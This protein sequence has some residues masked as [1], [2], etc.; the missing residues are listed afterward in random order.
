MAYLQ[1]PL[2]DE[3]QQQLQNG[4]QT[5]TQSGVLA[6]NS[7]SQQF[8]GTPTS[9]GYVNLDKYV[10]SNDQQGAGLANVVTSGANSA[11]EGAKTNAVTWGDAAKSRVDAGTV[12]DSSNIAGRVKANPTSVNSNEYTALQSASYGGP[13]S[14]QADT[15]YGDVLNTFKNTRQK[16]DSLSDRSTQKSILDDT[17]RQN[18]NQL[19]L[20][21]GQRYTNGFSNLD[22]FILNGDKAGQDSLKGFQDKAKGF[23]SALSDQEGNVGGYINQARSASDAAKA[24]AKAAVLDTRNQIYSGV[25][26]RIGE[27]DKRLRAEASA[28]AQDRVAQLLNNYGSDK[29]AVRNALN[30]NGAIDSANDYISVNGKVG[31]AQAMSADERARLQALASLESAQV[32]A[33]SSNPYAFNEGWFTGELNKA[34]ATVSAAKAVARAK[35]EAEA[36]AKAEADA[37]AAAEA[38]AREEERK[39]QRPENIAV[40]GVGQ[41][42]NYKV[43]NPTPKG[44]W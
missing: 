11:V 8:G 3:E 33:P 1:N 18:P 5:S 4:Q 38:A 10:T 20:Q 16:V 2:D 32:E 26:S 12:K 36:R 29:D 27:T 25:D 24:N 6:G 39:K 30:S 31:R 13:Q 34:N 42:G 21:Q 43:S 28:K 14:A 15:G 19:G 9:S 22:S 44:R 35:A 23:E 41:V 7:A 37:R 40:S 17:A